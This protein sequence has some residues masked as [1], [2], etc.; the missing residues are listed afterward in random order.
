ML[1]DGLPLRALI[2]SVAGWVNREQQR[3]IEYLVQ[4][5]RVLKE[6]LCGRRLRLTNDQRRRRAAKGK[7]L[8]RRLLGRV[9]TIVTP[10]TIMCW[11]RQ[12]IAAMWTYSSRATVRAGVMREISSLIVRFAKEDP[13][14]GYSRIQGAIRDLGHQVG[15]TIVARVLRKEG[16]KPAPERMICFGEA[17]LR[18]AL[19]EYVEHFNAER[20]HQGLCNRVIDGL[21]GPR[22]TPRRWVTGHDRLGGVLRHYRALAWRWDSTGPSGRRGPQRIVTRT[23]LVKFEVGVG[24]VSRCHA[25]KCHVS[26]G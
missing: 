16:I 18:R 7:Q 14:W 11:H 17:S 25:W 8:G 19:R 5:N 3:T 22:S 1:T 23:A 6:Q 2:L 12:L 21:A 4:E 9:A 24:F 10:D 15:R 26:P 13:T 20:P